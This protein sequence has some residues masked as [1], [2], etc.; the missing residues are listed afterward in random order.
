MIKPANE[1]KSL[2]VLNKMVKNSIRTVGSASK[3]FSFC[4]RWSRWC[5]FLVMTSVLRSHF[6][7]SSKVVP[8]YLYEWT[9]STFSSCISIALSVCL[10]LPSNYHLL[11]FVH[12]QLKV[13]L[14]TPFCKVVTPFCKVVTPFCKVVTPLCKVVTPFCK[15]VTPFCKV[16]EGCTVTILSSQKE[17]K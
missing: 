10:R 11:S 9:I 15:V 6:R 4:S 14:V 1:R 13:R 5:P 17:I 16:T 8:G 7:V 12:I 3:D 2:N